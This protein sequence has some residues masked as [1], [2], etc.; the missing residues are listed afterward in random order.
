MSRGFR[1]RLMTVPPTVVAST[2]MGV[3]IGMNGLAIQEAMQG[4][5]YLLVALGFL[6][7]GFILALFMF[8]RFLKSKGLMNGTRVMSADDIKRNLLGH[9]GP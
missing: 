5:S 2:G 7:L 8:V 3:A 1:I 9:R 6:V 4:V